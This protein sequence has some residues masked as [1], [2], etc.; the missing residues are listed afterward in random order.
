MDA[1]AMGVLHPRLAEIDL[2]LPALGRIGRRLVVTSRFA[3]GNMLPFPEGGDMPAHRPLRTADIPEAFQQPV[4]HLGRAHVR[5]AGEPGDHICVILFEHGFLADL[6]FRCL[7]I[8]KR[9]VPVLVDRTPAALQ[10][11]G[12]PLL[13]VAQPLRF[14]YSS[15]HADS[16]HGFT[17]HFRHRNRCLHCGGSS[18]PIRYG[19]NVRGQGL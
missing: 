5:M 12:G 16:L 14:L 7:V 8:V 15:V 10:P 18:S 6:G 2:R 1:P 4:E 3:A 9:H 13:G 11:L 17:P 19:Y